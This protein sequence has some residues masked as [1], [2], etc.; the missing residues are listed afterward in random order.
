MSGIAENIGSLQRWGGRILS[1]SRQL[2]P[3]WYSIKPTFGDARYVLIYRGG[4]LDLGDVYAYSNGVNVAKNKPAIAGAQGTDFA[5]FSLAN[6][7]D[8]NQTTEYS[9]YNTTSNEWVQIDL[10]QS[11]SIDKIVVLPRLSRPDRATNLV[12]LASQTPMGTAGQN[13]TLATLQASNA[14]SQ[15]PSTMPLTGVDSSTQSIN[16]GTVNVK[17]CTLVIASDASLGG[18]TVVTVNSGG[19]LTYTANTTGTR[20]VTVNAGGTVNKGGFAH[21]GTTFVNNGGTINP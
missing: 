12:V 17:A 9:F 7:T 15:F 18:S 21:T 11:F 2:Q 1:M 6:L 3:I 16:N 19:T 13:V 4:Q 10:G 5:P 8:E 20:T 14:W